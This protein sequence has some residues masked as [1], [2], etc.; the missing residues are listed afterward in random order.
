[1]SGRLRPA[2]G[3]VNVILSVLRDQRL[4]GR[5]QG[6]MAGVRRNHQR[7][8]TNRAD[9]EQGENAIFESH[10]G[11][12]AFPVETAYPKRCRAISSV[13]RAPRLHRGCRQFEPVIAHH[14]RSIAVQGF[15]PFHLDIHHPVK[16]TLQRSRMPLLYETLLSV[17]LSYVVVRPRKRIAALAS[18]APLLAQWFAY[19]PLRHGS[20][21]GPDQKKPTSS[22]GFPNCIL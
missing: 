3:G 16:A 9:E 19:R 10:Q 8:M 2:A 20:A 5:T 4:T 14:A 7:L 1:M 11:H 17:V 6:C 12:L 13:G 21:E 15:I 18:T 22:A